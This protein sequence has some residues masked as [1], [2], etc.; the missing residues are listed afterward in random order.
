MTILDEIIAQKR[1]EVAQRKEITPV[2]D[3][4]Q[5]P[6]FK[7]ICLSTRDA[8]QEFRSTGIIAEFKRKSPSKG[9]INAQSR[10]NTNDAGL[11]SGGGGCPVNLNR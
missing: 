2:S 4:E 3:L 10:C 11:R 1:I 9:I 6:D 8:V 5:M 7:R